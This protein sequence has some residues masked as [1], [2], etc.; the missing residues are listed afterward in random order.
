MG[1]PKYTN[2]GSTLHGRLG[3]KDLA[4]LVE[5]TYVD[6]TGAPSGFKK[7]DKSG[8]R[9]GQRNFR[10]PSAKNFYDGRGDFLSIKDIFDSLD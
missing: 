1:T 5:P 4:K 9:P 2:L 8:N 7:V 10:K 6:K 3:D